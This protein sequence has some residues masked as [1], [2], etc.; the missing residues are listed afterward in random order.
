MNH[1]FIPDDFNELSK[2]VY[3]NSLM[4]NGK[5]SNEQN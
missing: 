5:M 1:F 3:S 2:L 4:I